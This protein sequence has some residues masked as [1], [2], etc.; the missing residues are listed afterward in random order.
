MKSQWQGPLDRNLFSKTKQAI[1]H[2]RQSGSLPNARTDL[3]GYWIF[4]IYLG[5]L[6]PLLVH[7]YM[8]VWA[9]IFVYHYHGVPVTFDELR[10]QSNLGPR[11]LKAVLA[12]L[13]ERELII[14]TK[15]IKGF[16]SPD[17]VCRLCGK[18]K[19]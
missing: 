10:R 17:I 15:A 4:R 13:Y 9:I 12:Y 18:F 1:S 7:P 16:Y 14:S 6:P 5:E 3:N 19:Y 11:H 8:T 2:V